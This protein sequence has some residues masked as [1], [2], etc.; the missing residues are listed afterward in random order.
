MGAGEV[1]ARRLPEQV[2][3]QRCLQA[4]P[5]GVGGGVDDG[6]LVVGGPLVA[7]EELARTGEVLG[8]A[9]VGVAERLRQYR[10]G[11]GE[12]PRGGR[13]G[14]GEGV[15]RQLAGHVRQG[16]EGL[17]EPVA[18]L[19][20]GRVALS[21]AQLR[22][23]LPPDRGDDD[24]LVRR[25]EQPGDHRRVERGVG[26]TLVRAGEEALQLVEPH[27]ERRQRVGVVADPVDQRGVADLGRQYL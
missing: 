24:H 23:V 27:D 13:L 21:G 15:Q 25:P 1:P 14:R 12:L 3:G 18:V 22:E 5:A 9:V 20:G 7:A 6:T 17:G 16:V 19:A 10:I 11:L 8:D 26:G 4:E 2:G